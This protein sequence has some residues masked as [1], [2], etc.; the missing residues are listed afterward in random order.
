MSNKQRLT[1]LSRHEKKAALT[2][3]AVDDSIPEKALRE[4]LGKIHTH[5]FGAD[6][7]LAVV[8]EQAKYCRGFSTPGIKKCETPAHMQPHEIESQAKDTAAVIDELMSRIRHMNP[9]LKAKADEQLYGAFGSFA[10]GMIEN[11]RPDLYRLRA[12]LQRAGDDIG[13]S[14]KRGPKS[15]GK[16]DARRAVAATIMMH[17]KRRTPSRRPLAKDR[18]DELAG[19]L[20]DACG[21]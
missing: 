18:A 5:D 11:M 14:A 15:S 9:E 2:G 7:I 4:I 16:A 8:A 3:G 13:S 17:S 19:D 1:L 10:L 21:I 12:A 6:A 20:L